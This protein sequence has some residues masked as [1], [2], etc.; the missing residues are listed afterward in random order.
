MDHQFIWENA[1]PKVAPEPSMYCPSVL[2]TPFGPAPYLIM[3]TEPW[4][5]SDVYSR[6]LKHGQYTEYETN[7]DTNS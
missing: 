4:G 2:I 1:Y 5:K 7:D 6:P 3:L